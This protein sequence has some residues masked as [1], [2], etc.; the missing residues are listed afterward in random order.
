MNKNLYS[1]RPSKLS[2]KQ[3]SRTKCVGL[4]NY[5]DVYDMQTPMTEFEYELGRCDMQ[6][7]ILDKKGNKYPVAAFMQQQDQGRI[8]GG[9]MRIC[10]K[11]AINN[12]IL[13]FSG[14]SGV[15]SS[16]YGTHIINDISNGYF[17]EDY[18]IK[19]RQYVSCSTN[20]DLNAICKDNE[21]IEL[22]YETRKK[23]EFDSKY[24]QL[25]S[26]VFVYIINGE[27][28]YKDDLTNGVQIPFA[29][30]LSDYFRNYIQKFCD[31]RISLDNVPFEWF[32]DC[33]FRIYPN[34]N[35][36]LAIETRTNTIV[37]IDAAKQK[38]ITKDFLFVN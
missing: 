33:Y 34:N 19:N 9:A 3:V 23:N 4:T 15:F 24:V 22:S 5:S 2:K 32:N 13:V 8:V 7:Y 30:Y 29:D 26:N 20:V 11:I 6:G 36:R 12:D 14:Y 28:F 21:Y 31:S 17:L 35:Y 27:F 18:I 1:I 38:K 10:V 25:S 37:L 16:S